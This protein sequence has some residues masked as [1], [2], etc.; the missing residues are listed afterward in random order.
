VHTDGP[1]G[2]GLCTADLTPGSEMATSKAPQKNNKKQT[3]P[4]PCR[5]SAHS[6]FSVTLSTYV[7][8]QPDPML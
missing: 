8:Y 4:T 3:L 5:E 7:R 1:A 6:S 2:G